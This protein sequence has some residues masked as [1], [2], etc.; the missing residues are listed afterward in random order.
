M[1][2]TKYAQIRQHICYLLLI[3]NFEVKCQ[4]YIS[5]E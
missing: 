4:N 1:T 3:A 5:T 2:T